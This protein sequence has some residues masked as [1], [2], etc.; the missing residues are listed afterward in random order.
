MRINYTG[1]HWEIV[2]LLINAGAD[3]NICDAIL[4]TPLHLA[5]KGCVSLVYRNPYKNIDII[6][7]V[8]DV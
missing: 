6:Y 8:A 4:L 7:K 5:A 1:G 2:Q 3:V